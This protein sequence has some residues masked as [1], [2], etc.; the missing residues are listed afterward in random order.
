MNNLLESRK[1]WIAIVAMVCVTAVVIVCLF[2]KVPEASMMTIAATIGGLAY[3]LI[4]ARAKVDAA[5]AVAS[6][7]APIIATVPPPAPVA[8]V[9]Q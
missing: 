7:P 2:L 1:F 3:K 5:Y 9:E 6:A 8:E 4:D